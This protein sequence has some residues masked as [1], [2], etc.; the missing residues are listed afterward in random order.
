MTAIGPLSDSL[1]LAKKKQKV[2]D[3]QAV[4]TRPVFSQQIDTK[5]KREAM[6]MLMRFT[7]AEAKK[8]FRGAV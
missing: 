3:Q 4:R 6:K 5:T 8:V 1:R 2:V 7:L